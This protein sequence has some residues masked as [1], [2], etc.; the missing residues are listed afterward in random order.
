MGRRDQRER[1]RKR[2]ASTCQTLDRFLPAAKR[3]SAREDP[4]ASSHCDGAS[5]IE[6]E[7]PGISS[8]V[9]PGQSEVGQ[10]EPISKICDERS[11]AD[12]DV[13]LPVSQRPTVGL[14]KPSGPAAAECVDVGLFVK[15][16]E[17]EQEVAQKLQELPQEKKYALLTQHKRPPQGFQFPTTF[18]GGCNRSFRPS[19][20]SDHRWLAYSTQLDGAFCV[21]CALFNGSGVKGRLQLGKLVTRPF[22]AWQK[23]SEKFAEH[24]STKYHQACMELADDL[25]RRIE[26]PQQ[27]LPVLLDQRR[28]ENIEK[29]RAIVKSLAR[30]VLFCGRQCIALRGG[31]EQLD[32]PGNP[33]N[34]L[35]LV[36]LLS[37]HDE[38]LRN[39]L[40]SPALRNVTYVSPRTQNEI[41]EV[42]GHH[43]ILKDLV[44]EIKAAR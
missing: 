40:E 38:L 25:K 42:L 20:L 36:R 16:C 19:W 29:N 26:H 4:E 15:D 34:F 9:H 43:I 31:S 22:R 21:P 28:A 17:S 7:P 11:G 18:V 5:L 44:S 2:A 6:L 41:I 30:A 10:E 12:Q 8:P 33:G 3:V 32:T 14:S 1:E 39:H 13:S 35:A 37:E 24:Q 27:A 23:M